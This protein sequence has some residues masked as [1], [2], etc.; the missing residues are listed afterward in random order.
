MYICKSPSVNVGWLCALVTV[1][2]CRGLCGPQ[3][4]EGALRAGTMFVSV[5]SVSLAQESSINMCWVSV[6]VYWGRGW[7]VTCIPSTAVWVSP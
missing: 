7:Q 5:I 3:D 1:G 4:P 2:M 6:N